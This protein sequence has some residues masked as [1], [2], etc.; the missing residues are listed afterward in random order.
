MCVTQIREASLSR[1]DDQIRIRLPSDLKD[2]VM[3]QAKINHRSN[4]SQIVHM[5]ESLRADE[6]VKKVQ[7]S[8]KRT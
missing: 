7:R 4:N 1:L 3:D 8:R 6:P 5:L 2:W